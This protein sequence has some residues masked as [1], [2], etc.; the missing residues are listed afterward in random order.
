MYT[1][2]ESLGLPLGSL[3]QPG[4]FGL[5]AGNAGIEFG[6]SAGLALQRFVH[7]GQHGGGRRRDAA[8]AATGRAIA[9]QAFQSG[10]PAQAI[11]IGVIIEIRIRTGFS[12]CLFRG[13]FSVSWSSSRA[14]YRHFAIHIY[15][16]ECIPTIKNE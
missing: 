6:D 8:M 16:G 12:I 7:L 4:Q 10:R 2:D 5:V 11:E 15:A 13:E 1:A 14:Y 3:A 9:A